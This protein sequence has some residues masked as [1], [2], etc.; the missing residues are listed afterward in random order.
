MGN[1]LESKF[2]AELKKEIKQRL[3]GCI[4]IKQ[5]ASYI[6]GIPDLLILHKDR[7]AALEVKAHAKAHRQP[8]QEYYV[9][10]L[11]GM[12]YAAFIHPGNK[13]DVLDALYRSFGS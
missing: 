10:K 4:V 13:E 12:S 6:Q 8:N 11:D 5:D 1:L 3:P 7:W 9:D 2:Q